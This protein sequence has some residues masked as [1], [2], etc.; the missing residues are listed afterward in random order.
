MSVIIIKRGRGKE[1]F[2]RSKLYNSIY[3]ACGLFHTEKE[4]RKISSELTRSV[5]EFIKGKK[6]IRSTGI[7]KKVSLELRKKNKE[8]SFSY[9]KCLPNLK[10]L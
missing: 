8:L 6:E 5:Q 10:K 1:K 4:C 7:S 9:D 3:M 2:S